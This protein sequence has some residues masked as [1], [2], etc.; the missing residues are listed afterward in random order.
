M[1]M[2]NF[3][4]ERDDKLLEADKYTFSVLRRVMKGECVLLLA[5]HER[6]IICHTDK[7]Y[8]VWICLPYG[9]PDAD[10]ERACLLSK[11]NGLLDGAHTF[12]M[13]Y[14]TAE[15][16]IERAEKDGRKLAITLNMFAYDCRE[17]IKPEISV[18]GGLYRCTPADIDEV[19]ELV[20]GFWA[21]ALGEKRDRATDRASAEEFIAAGKMFLWKD[22]SGRTAACCK[23][24][25]SGELASLGLVYTLPGYR[26][27]HYAQ[28]LVYEV[29]KLAAGEGYL[30]AL[31]TNADYAAS[32]GCYVKIGYI[33]RGRLCTIG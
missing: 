13:K 6:L 18:D 26:R 4:D 12:N 11:E 9:T 15:Y 10:M 27:K 5:D 31:Y 2:D 16:F 19:T 30:P 21:E 33:L 22:G 7:P 29:T 25:P 3:T 8:P 23:Y 17:P 32:N 28:N 14:E 24:I 20:S 1:K